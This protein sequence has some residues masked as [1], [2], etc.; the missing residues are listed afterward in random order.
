MTAWRG[1]SKVLRQ[2]YDY[3]VIDLPPL[4][5]VVDVRATKRIVDTYLLV[6]QWGSTK[7]PLIEHALGEAPGVYENLLGVVLNKVD[8]NVARRYDGHLKDY[9]HNKHFARYGYVD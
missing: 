3:V 1:S 5:P 6:V 7:I 9:Y 2:S 8:M 4:A